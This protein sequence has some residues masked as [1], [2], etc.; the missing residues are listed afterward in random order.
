MYIVPHFLYAAKMKMQKMTNVQIIIQYIFIYILNG[1]QWRKI[2]FQKIIPSSLKVCV[3][4][5]LELIFYLY[6]IVEACNT[7]LSP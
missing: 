1:H 3:D 7:I 6:M 4:F 5:G 2:G